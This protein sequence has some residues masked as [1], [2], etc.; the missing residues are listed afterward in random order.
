MAALFGDYEVARKSGFF[1]PDYYLATYPDV[2][3]RNVDPLVHYLEEG[4]REGRNPHPDFDSAF[5]LA[6][7]KERGEAPE[8]P[9][10]HYIRIGA[11]RGFRTRRD[12]DGLGLPAL[13]PADPTAAPG[14]MP[15]LVAVETL[16][17]AGAPGGGSRLSIG[18]WA[19]APAPIVEISA[20]IDGDIVGHANYGLPRPDVAQIYPER[21]GAAR[22][23]FML[24]VELPRLSGGKL[25]PMLT[26]RTADGDIGR[27]ALSV[28]V[29]PQE[30]EVSAIDPL[31]PPEAEP[32][33]PAKSPMHLHID[34]A[35]V[36][37]DGILRVEGWVV[38]LIQ[39]ESVEAFID[40]ERI[41]EAEFG[42]VR[43]D[44]EKVWFDY[45][46]SRF[47][48][49]LLA[50]KVSRLGAGKK[51]V[52]LRATAR[53]GIA[54]EATAPVII[55][56]PA[57]G[58]SALEHGFHHHCDEIALTTDGAVALKGWAVCASPTASIKVLLDGEAI[59]EAE[60]GAERADVGNMLPTL[61]HARRSAFMFRGHAGKRLQGEHL[62][63]LEVLG[64]GGETHEIALPV[65]AVESARQPDAPVSGT[66]GDAERK[67]QLDVPSVIG[68]AMEM[69]VRGN[70]E[71]SG[72]A[73][74]RTGVDRIEI[75]V[76]GT[77]IA[78]ADYGLRRL[79]IQAAFPDWEN[80]LA[81]GYL[82]LVPHRILP[83]G[84]HTVSVSLRDRTGK[85]VGIEF[86]IEVETLSEL[87]GPW[88]LKR[89]MS[90]A[91]IDLDQRILD[92]RNWQP[93]FC[94]VLPTRADPES[95]R[96]ARATLASLAAQIYP[97]WQLI[98]A[99]PSGGDSPDASEDRLRESLA[100]GLPG[101]SDR[102][103]IEQQLTPDILRASLPRGGA[104]AAPTFFSVLTPGD[105]L[106][107]DALLEMAF[108]T[109]MHGEA[110]FIYSD[111][112]RL[113]PATGSVE[114]FFKPQWSPD[115]LLSTNYI[116][117]LWC[118]RAELLDA[119]AGPGDDLLQHGEYDL[120]LR[121][122]E[123]AKAIRHIP[124]VLC[125]RTEKSG[126]ERGD[127][128]LERAIA[129]RGIAGE[130]RA[131]LIPGTY[132]VKRAAPAAGL[133]S[134]IIPTCAAQGMIRTCI[135]TLRRVS[136][137]QNFE[138][139]CIENIPPADT[140]SR[141]WLY[142]NADWVVS[143]E[144]P[145][146][147]SR[148]NN[149]AA[150]QA[151]G[152]YLLFLND[153]IEIIEPGW[154]DVLIEQAQR[155]EVG[156]VGPRLLYPDRRVQHAGIFLAAMGQGRHAFRY[157]G[158][159]DPGYFGLALTER[160]VIAVTGACLLTRRETYDELGGF[161]EAHDVI[162]NDLDYCLRAWQRGLVNIYTPH[163]RLIHHEAVSRAGLADDYDTAVFDTR[164]R[165]LFLNGDPY[166][167]PNLAKNRDD[168]SPDAEPTRIVVTGGPV[169]V[170]EDLRKILVVK[171]DHIGDC[172]MAFPAIRRL[173]R[174]F[175]Q[176]RI[177]VLT[178]RSSRSV[179]SL[180]PAV[181]DIFEFDFFHARSALGELERTEADF[182]ELRD[183]LA[184]EHFD[185]AVDLR[186]HPE[187]RSVLQYTGARYLAG[188]DHRSQ[189]TWLDIALDW[190]GDQAFARKRNHTAEDLVNLVDAIAAA[191]DEDRT[192]ITAPPAPSA[193]PG[194]GLNGTGL[195]GTAGAP[196]VCVHPSAGNE[197]KQWPVE[198]FASL[199]DQLVETDGARVA[200]IG[201]PGEEEIAA[202]IIARL[203]HPE[204]ATSLVGKIPL[205]ELPAMLCGA[206]LFVGNDSGPK[207]IAAGLGVPTVGIHSGTVDVREWGPIGPSALAVAREVVCS[208]CYL[209]RPEDCR[210]GLA[211]LHQLAPDKV[212]QAC[213]R[214][215]LLR[216]PAP[217]AVASD[218]GP[219]LRP[220]HPARSRD[221]AAPRAGTPAQANLL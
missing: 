16:G 58:R 30:V 160:N 103:R 137:N 91:E 190:G 209:S 142:R 178:S 28:D 7:C 105:E 188:F 194:A 17:V 107:C 204:M 12:T 219:A 184:G 180:E 40:D 68:G 33:T 50:S 214:L 170:S 172:I 148:F 158:E 218:N 186:K 208:P 14:K 189:F 173:K 78:L 210:R 174:H 196:L 66:I 93:R 113:N 201:A 108:A 153:D 187:T 74:A 124:A 140:E 53:T 202:G 55:P 61:A 3:E 2:G 120:V 167:N 221:R 82:C 49:F 127:E 212:Y 169:L 99:P 159:N 205:S 4:S 150:S 84:T 92:S 164:W 34:H 62:I 131:G 200:L 5:Y 215:L 39:I 95:L 29:P 75:A 168:F 72:W 54:R 35:A 81:S 70:L 141:D 133:V 185:L 67:L 175:P 119:L 136:A 73:L 56:E 147:W 154:L 65:L 132:R 122:T 104:L 128:A 22:S 94:V 13:A 85:T 89:K 43:E 206:A 10:I 83:T 114:A 162:N 207:H 79:D 102:I 197:M 21:E 166:F 1:D 63:T 182:L 6:Q 183:R 96:R 213:K 199:I 90:Q 37:D 98:V 47:S 179:W 163:A 152:E 117:R 76:D 156:V 36:D 111:E 151:T 134:I 181:D 26:V 165:D 130:I 77:P 46:N 144:E 195:N 101:V 177:S 125:E 135:E 11:A 87:T 19:L 27:R 157:A 20:T 31:T 216:S 155:P 149:L 220:A 44:V 15:I 146:N 45:P 48:G 38:C 129:R 115:L 217:A 171:L 59:G 80:A 121:C 198:Y 25:E 191:A 112:R 41:G 69:P 57:M 176:V 161:D 143:T 23:G 88:S 109:A 211:C 52:T 110:D 71:I 100:E 106:G 123:T 192:V 8:N 64:E 97:N 24:T 118:A 18:G 138:I 60:A 51:V 203:R 42:R 86:R 9:L 193:L 139:I 32:A 126:D 116:G 145:F